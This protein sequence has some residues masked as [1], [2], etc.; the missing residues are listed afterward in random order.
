MYRRVRRRV[1]ELKEER[2]GNN[3]TDIGKTRTGEKMGFE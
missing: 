2:G 3:E 1:R